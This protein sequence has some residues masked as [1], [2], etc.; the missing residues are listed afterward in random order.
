MVSCSSSCAGRTDDQSAR[1]QR[2][3]HSVHGRPNSCLPAGKTN[4]AAG[5]PCQPQR[6]MRPCAGHRRCPCPSRGTVAATFSSEQRCRSRQLLRNA[7]ERVGCPAGAE[8][9]RVACCVRRDR[10]RTVQLPMAHTGAA[11]RVVFLSLPFILMYS[12]FE[13]S[14][15]VP[16][17]TGRTSTARCS[18]A[19]AFRRYLT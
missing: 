5:G 2:E 6:A 11:R 1:A 8:L 15:Q 14:M 18:A 7:L 12:A 3:G 19:T 9:L 10:A 17:V 4:A 16:F 13:Q